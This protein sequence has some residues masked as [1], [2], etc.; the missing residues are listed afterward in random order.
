MPD[1]LTFSKRARQGMLQSVFMLAF[2]TVF[3]AVF[4]FWGF[5]VTALSIIGCAVFIGVALIIFF[6]ALKINH[7]LRSLPDEAESPAD[8]RAVKQ[9][10][11]IASVQGATIGIA[12]AILGMTG[13]YLYIVPVVVLI[14]GIHYFPLGAIYRT[15]IHFIVGIPVVLIA[16][17]GIVVQALGVLGNEVIGICACAAALSTAILGVYIMRLVQ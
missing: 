6:K 4:L 17:S 15:P 3:W 1:Q 8:K 9:W 12:C 11:I 5:Y 2:F 7:S 13:R 14:V 10:N 16:V